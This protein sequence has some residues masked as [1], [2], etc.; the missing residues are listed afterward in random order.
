MMRS[1]RSRLIVGMLLGML[2]L[3]VAASTTIYTVQRRQL[4]RAFDDT[5]LN[6]ANALALLFHPGPF[7]TWFDSEGLG[8]LPAGQIRQGALFQFWSDQPINI[9]LAPPDP[10]ADLNEFGFRA[11]GD[12]ERPPREPG[13]SAPGDLE[14]P[15]REPGFRAPDDL[16]G[17]PREPGPRPARE[18][19]RPPEPWRL[20]PN[21]PDL[22]VPRPPPEPPEDWRRRGPGERVIRSPLLEGADLPCL[23]TLPGRPRFENIT[24]PDGADGRAVALQYPLPAGAPWARREAPARLT[25]VVAAGIAELERQLRFLGVLLLATSVGTMAVAGGVAWLVVSRGLQPL[26][27]VARKIATLD[28]TGLKQRLAGGGAPREIEP[29]VQQLN[30]LLARLDEAFER[31][32]ALTADVAHELRTPV[33]EI[34]AIT[35]ITLSRARSPEEYRQALAETQDAIRT[36]QELIERLLVLARLEAGQVRPQLETTPLYPLIVQHWS[37]QRDRAAARGLLFANDCPTDAVVGADP[38]LVDVVLANV[39]ANAAEYTPDHGSITVTFRPAG[40]HGVLTIANTGCTLGPADVARVFDRF[41][42]AD[43]ARSRT[44]LNCG[45]GLTLVRRAME[46]M[47]GTAEARVSPDQ[48]F[49]VELTLPAPTAGE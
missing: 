34:R 24:L 21:R 6:S 22:Q 42:R 8:R 38:K 19:R 3:L 10:N 44:G 26:A 14:R 40:P 36:L 32:R 12:L 25:A 15:A 11:P 46:A 1:L 48:C 27:V 5:L 45:L 35:D 18:D 31:E 47:G 41:W 17:P 9:P 2:L 23:N 20:D 37:V 49:L 30:G 13:P 16:E 4:Y 7:G 28:E 33:A 39:L 43:A 29:V